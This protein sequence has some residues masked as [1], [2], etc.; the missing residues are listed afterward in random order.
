MKRKLLFT[1]FWL[2]KASKATKVLRAIQG[3]FEFLI[4]QKDSGIRV[5]VFDYPDGKVQH[6]SAAKSLELAKKACENYYDKMA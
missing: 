2:Y 3:K 1:E 6:R 5:Q 4:R